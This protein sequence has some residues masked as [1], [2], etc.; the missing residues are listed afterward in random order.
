[1]DNKINATQT[2]LKD[3]KWWD[4]HAPSDAEALLDFNQ[5]VKWVNGEEFWWTV[6][7]PCWLSQAGSSW[8]A[9]RYKGKPETFTLYERPVVS[10]QKEKEWIPGV[11]PPTRGN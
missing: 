2:Q 4:E 3:P 8:S 9:G 10:K 5:W 6:N 7:D 1:M 11:T